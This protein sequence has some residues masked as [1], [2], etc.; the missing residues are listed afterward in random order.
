M[1][2]LKFLI[3][4]LPPGR[5]IPVLLAFE[6]ITACPPLAHPVHTFPRRDLQEKSLN[7]PPPIPSNLSLFFLAYSLRLTKCR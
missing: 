6:S 2:G 1:V 4:P 5:Q 3:P 7:P